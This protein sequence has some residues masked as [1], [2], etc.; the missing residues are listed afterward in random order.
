MM[1]ILIALLLGFSTLFSAETSSANRILFLMQAGHVDQAL[2]IYHSYAAERGQHDFELLRN[3]GMGLLDQGARSNE[4]EIQLLTLFGA[5]ISMNESALHIMEE[6][7][8]NK[9]PILQVI[10]MNLLSQYQND[11]ADAALNRALNSPI[12]IIRLQGL[13]HLA[14]KKAP[15]AIPQAEALMAKLDQQFWPIFPEIYG[16]V[17]NAQA[18]RIM[19]K[20]LSNHREDVRIATILSAA[21]Y[22]RDDLLPTIRILATHHSIAQQE[23]CATALGIMKDEASVNKLETIGSSG[24]TT[25]RLAAL[26]ALYRLGRKEVRD[27]IENLAKQNDLYAITILGEIEGSEDLLFELT[28]NSNVHVKANAAIALL[29]RKDS[30]CLKPLCDVLIAD[31][32]DFAI[33]VVVSPG[34]SLKAFKMIPSA[35]Q[36]LEEDSAAHEMSL[37]L[38][39]KFVLDATVLSEKDFLALASA[40]FEMRQND[41]VPVLVEALENMRT[42]GAIELLKKYQQ[43]AGAPLIR[44]YCN[45]SLYRLKEEGP[46]AENLHAWI[47]KE[48]NGELIHFRPLLAFG[49][50]EKMSTASSVHQLTPE[51]TSRLLI[52]SFEA[53]IQN[54][55]DQGIDVLLH[56]IQYGNAKNRYALAGLLIFAAQ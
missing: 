7:L 19:R 1:K 36:N 41:L 25:K 35:Q 27:Q 4:A 46:Y 51:E 56:A 5:G 32:R 28:K 16:I 20:L 21:Q 47:A 10:S 44:N 23:A 31:V 40:L 48:Q 43:K 24:T 55:D 11:D 6:G 38:R 13:Y 34:G 33:E 49:A 53:L 26:Q 54:Q 52:E 9:N 8:R 14:K 17:G 30:R 18:M 45:L 50:K 22:G 2:N 39:E 12:M 42:P 29:Q 37:S 15:N 3:I